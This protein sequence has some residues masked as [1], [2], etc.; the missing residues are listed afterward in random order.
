M[1]PKLSLLGIMA[2]TLSSCGGGDAIPFTSGE[3]STSN[4]NLTSTPTP[5]P[6]R[7]A[8]ITW[9]ANKEKAVNQAGGGYIVY[10]SSSQNFTTTGASMVNVPYSSGA[11]APNQ[12]TIPNLYRGQRYY[13][14]IVAFSALIPPGSTNFAKSN[15][16]TELAIDIP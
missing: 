1:R 3:T 2:I 10:Y 12:A 7:S 15:N 6:T 5:T 4:P 16:S 8:V 11:L 13:V 14:K 9:T